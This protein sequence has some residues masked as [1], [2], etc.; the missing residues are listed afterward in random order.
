[1]INKKILFDVDEF[2]LKKVKDSKLSAFFIK[3]LRFVFLWKTMIVESRLISNSIS[4][5]NYVKEVKKANF[6]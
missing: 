3:C 1:M 5:I 2:R 6:F 4:E